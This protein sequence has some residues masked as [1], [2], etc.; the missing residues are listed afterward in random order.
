M[1][2][3][4]KQCRDIIALDPGVNKYT[5]GDDEI[6]NISLIDKSS[7]NVLLSK[8]VAFELG[9]PSTASQ[10][11]VIK[12]S[13]KQLVDNNSVSHIGPDFSEMEMGEKYAFAQVILL[14]LKDDHVYDPFQIEASQY[15]SNKLAGYSIRSIPGKLWARVSKKQLSEGLNIKQI[16]LA[17]NKVYR[18]DFPQI[19]AME[20]LF[21]TGSKEKVLSL[22]AIEEQV[23]ASSKQQKK[24]SLKAFGDMD[25]SEM[26]C[27]SCDEVDICDDV[28]DVI[29]IKRRG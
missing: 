13:D 3:Y 26:N 17:L 24:E 23:R 5:L 25:C 22:L 8:N 19:E 10:A 9:H 15:L 7:A 20:I 11:F 18:M 1:K 4:I 28:R 16:A 14:A 29:K 6:L 12:T 27:K 2:G 21:V